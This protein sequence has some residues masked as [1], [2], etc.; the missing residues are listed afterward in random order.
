VIEK[1]VTF[2]EK[3]EKK[4]GGDVDERVGQWK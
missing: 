2:V 3:K 1:G 4:N